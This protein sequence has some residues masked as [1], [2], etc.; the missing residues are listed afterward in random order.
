MCPATAS[1]LKGLREICDETG[2]L[3]VFDE[4]YSR[5]NMSSW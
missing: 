3:L 5:V 1:F 4:V 2:T